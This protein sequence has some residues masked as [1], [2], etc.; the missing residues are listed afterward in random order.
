MTNGAVRL[1]VVSMHPNLSADRILLSAHCCIVDRDRAV[2]KADAETSERGWS[3]ALRR[4][5]RDGSR[6]HSGRQEGIANRPVIAHRPEGWMAGLVGV[7]RPRARS[8]GCRRL[9]AGDRGVEN[10]GWRRVGEDRAAQAPA[11]NFPRA[12]QS[13]V[14]LDT[15]CILSDRVTIALLSPLACTPLSSC[16]R[17]ASTACLFP[18]RTS[19]PPPYSPSPSSV[20]ST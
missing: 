17:P 19:F 7:R 1:R 4:S 18:S 5:S 15:R 6:E 2:R 11:P 10:G 8:S 16:F 3:G 20:Q 13:C 9:Q 14:P 12:V